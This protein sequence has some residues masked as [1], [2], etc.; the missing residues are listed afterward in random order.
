[1]RWTNT[2][3]HDP[4][5]II[6]NKNIYFQTIERLKVKM[7]AGGTP[8]TYWKNTSLDM[9][10]IF[11]TS[12]TRCFC[13]QKG[14]S[15]P[16]PRHALCMG[17]GVLSGYQKYGFYEEVY[18][19][20]SIG[21][22]IIKNPQAQVSSTDYSVSIAGNVLE[23]ELLTQPVELTG[24]KVFDHV[25]ISDICD[26]TNNTVEYYYSFD[27]ATWTKMTLAVY[28]VSPLANKT[29]KAFNIPNTATKIWFKIKL[30][31]RIL[32]ASSP[33][34]NWMRFRYRKMRTLRSIAP[35]YTIDEPAFLS[36]REQQKIIVEGGEQGWETKYPVIWWA[37][38]EVDISSNDV[39]EFYNGKYKGRKFYIHWFEPRFVGP[40]MMQTSTSFET[41]LIRDDND[42]SGILS[43]L[44]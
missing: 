22:T 36:C 41:K 12:A 23:V 1:M 34:F 4:R 2:Y 42:L 43:Y 37:L 14:S 35:R 39:I 24:E 7:L 16:D 40:E 19:S 10:G 32:A 25:L 21:S 31:K 17:T 15:Q 33:S 8:C 3:R 38:P 29:A 5:R 13:Y 11:N 6:D 20:P 9:F 44:I 26:N 27:N 30:R 28:N 18:A